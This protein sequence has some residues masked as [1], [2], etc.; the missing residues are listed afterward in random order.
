MI[1][2]GTDRPRAGQVAVRR[3]ADQEYRRHRRSDADARLA[4]YA[5]T[6]RRRQ[7]CRQRL[8]ALSHEAAL[9]MS[10]CGRTDDL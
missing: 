8:A 1:K 10:A 2:T 5:I 9:I 3:A 7:E 4:E 6:K